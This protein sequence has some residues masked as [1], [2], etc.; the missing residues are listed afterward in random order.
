MNIYMYIYV[1]IDGYFYKIQGDRQIDRKTE[2]E[3]E[4]EREIDDRQKK[5][6]R[7]IDIMTPIYDK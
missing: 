5:R 3:G 2:K 6:H 7:D 4:I 1:F